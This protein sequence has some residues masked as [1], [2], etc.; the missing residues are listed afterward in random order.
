MQ[1]SHLQLKRT[2]NSLFNHNSTTR[3]SGRARTRSNLPR[4]SSS[5]ACFRPRIWWIYRKP[6]LSVV[7]TSPFMK[8]PS[9]WWILRTLCPRI[10]IALL[11]MILRPWWHMKGSRIRYQLSF[12]VGP[13]S[14]IK[15]S[16]HRKTRTKSLP[17]CRGRLKTWKTSTCRTSQTSH[18][19]WTWSSARMIW[20]P[21]RVSLPFS[22]LVENLFELI[23]V[24]LSRMPHDLDKYATSQHLQEAIQ[25][26]RNRVRTS[27]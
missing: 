11:L 25:N 1:R 18:Q 2:F 23:E 5:Q 4:T 21:S 7:L 19:N 8:M 15:D 20:T 6:R 27:K 22:L 10:E 14:L 17:K 13:P 26:L 24:K 12:R 16:T 9:C 3:L